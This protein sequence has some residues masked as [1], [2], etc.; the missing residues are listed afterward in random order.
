MANM[1]CI[2]AW[3][4]KLPRRLETSYVGNVHHAC[5][6]PNRSLTEGINIAFLLPVGKESKMFLRDHMN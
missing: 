1:L 2:S 6:Y 5:C 4:Q 3:G